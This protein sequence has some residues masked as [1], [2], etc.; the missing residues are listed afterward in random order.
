MMKQVNV[1]YVDVDTGEVLRHQRK[2]F[3]SCNDYFSDWLHTETRELVRI[4]RA[5]NIAFQFSIKDIQE[6]I[7]LF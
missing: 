1:D 6:E 3:S 4:A 2:I 7:E 5:R